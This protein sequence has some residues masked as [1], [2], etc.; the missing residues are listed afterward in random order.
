[1]RIG[2]TILWAAS[3]IALTSVHSISQDP[4]NRSFWNHNG[5]TVY[6]VAKGSSR[7]FFY[8]DPR[9]GMIEAGARRGS[10]LFQ[11][12][13]VGGQYVGT[14]FL[15]NA[16]CGTLPYKVSGPILDN[17]E[18]VLV[19]GQA[20]IV[21]SDCHVKRYAADTLEFTLLKPGAVV[22]AQTP[23]I[24]APGSQAPANGNSVSVS[25][26]EEGGTF[27]IPVL[28]NN[29]ITLNFVV[30]SGASHV[31]IP[32]DVMLTLVR[33]GT[34]SSSDF[35]GS[36]TYRLADGS[37]M[38]S[39]TF[40]IRSLRVG[41]KVVQNVVGSVAPIEGSLLLGQSFLSRFRSWSVDNGAHA[42]VLNE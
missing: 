34:L 10:L 24:P 32:A 14:A 28:I 38:P 40:R 22:G 41:N 6:L 42:L 3:S 17:Y 35:I 11:G 7:Q 31:S 1:M 2:L 23:S 12:V 29:A 13:S 27:T 5:S 9:A 19:K 18:R 15:Y 36:E 4:A 39:T 21:D 16:N 25:M 20:P 8:E 33:T 26:Q 37:T 30:D